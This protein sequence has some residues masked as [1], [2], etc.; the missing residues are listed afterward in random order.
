MA[1]LVAELR[2]TLADPEQPEPLR[3][4]AAR[5]LRLLA[6]TDVHGRPV[7][8]SADPATWWGLR[9]PTRSD[10]P[11]RPA[12]EPLT[13]S[14]SAL[15]G[16]LTCPAQW[17]LQREAGGEVVSS[18]SQGFGKVVHAIAERIA[19]GELG[20]AATRDDLMPLVDEV[21]GRM[22]FRTPWS[23]AREREAVFAALARFV[24]WHERPGART[25]V[26][27]E[28][29]M[30][31]R[32]RR[33]P[34][35]RSSAC[36]DTPTGSSSMRTAAWWSSTSRPASTPQLTRTSRSTPSSASTSSRSTTGQPTSTVGSSAASGGAELVQLRG[37]DVLPKVQ[38]QS[39]PSGDGP[40][41]VEE[42][43]MQAAAALRVRGV[44]RTPRPALPAVHVPG[45]LPRQDRRDGARMTG[46]AIDTP[47]AA[48]RP[49]RGR[50]DVQRSAVRGDHGPARARGRDRRSRLRQ[51]GGDG[52]PGGV[53][54]RDRTG[55]TR[56]GPGSH[57]HHQGDRRAPEADPRQPARRRPAARAGA[58]RRTTR[59]R[60][61]SRRS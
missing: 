6:E 13:L 45:H 56:R 25:V 3:A 9:E 55:L 20:A 42:Q 8:A 30:T 58:A 18:T 15:E 36:T 14:A 27:V 38:H 49:A 19:R 4:A 24:A 32:G 37:G 61:R 26:A 17:F 29:R 11:V 21:W 43:L 7:A 12:A 57:L 10:Q 51:D 52:G 5:R 59:R 31:G 22:E 44:R 46:R 53:A 39:R 34:T 54:G 28:P 23:R 47:A 35:V 40:R 60:S 48:A 41:P 1:G 2:R 50:L 33:F 16:L